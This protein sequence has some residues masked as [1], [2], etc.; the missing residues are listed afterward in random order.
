[1]NPLERWIDEELGAPVQSLTLSMRRLNRAWR[2]VQLSLRDGDLTSLPAYVTQ[3]ESHVGQLPEA[4]SSLGAKASQYDIKA[5]LDDG[6]D[7]DFRNACQAADLPLE[8]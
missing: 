6:F 5:Y 2:G 3:F 7:A 1:M 4:A 8:G